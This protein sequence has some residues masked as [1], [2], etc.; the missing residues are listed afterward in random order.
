MDFHTFGGGTPK[1]TTKKFDEIGRILV[2][3]ALNRT[4]KIRKAGGEISTICRP[5]QLEEP[6]KNSEKRK[7]ENR[8]IPKSPET[9]TRFA[10]G[11]AA[12]D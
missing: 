8:Q 4:K 10:R 12:P 6:K 9:N 2:P 1:K 5:E 7:S 3:G 11:V